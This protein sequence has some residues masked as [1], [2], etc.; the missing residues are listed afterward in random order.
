MYNNLLRLD[1]H[2]PLQRLIY[3]TAPPLLCPSQVLVQRIQQPPQ[4]LDRVALLRHAKL[5]RAPL[6]DLLQKLVWA[7]LGFK[8]PWV[9]QAPSEGR[10]PQDELGGRWFG[11]RGELR[12]GRGEKEIADRGD[13][14]EEV[15]D[16]VEIGVVGDVVD[17]NVARCERLVGQGVGG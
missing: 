1:P 10:K 14:E 17:A 16:D 12:G 9:P 3:H 13:V 11:C 8:Q 5:A 7:H 4:K 6:V 2:H 15:D